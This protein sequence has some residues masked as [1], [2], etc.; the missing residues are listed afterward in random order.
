MK[1]AT[2][3]LISFVTLQTFIWAVLLVFIIVL[4]ELLSLLLDRGGWAHLVVLIVISLA[5][6]HA[7]EDRLRPVLMKWL[8]LGG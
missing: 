6:G 2:R 4:S 1:R 3:E 8:N 5:A 7:C